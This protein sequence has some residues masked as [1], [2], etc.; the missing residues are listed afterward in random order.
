MTFWS[1]Q[2]QPWGVYA[3]VGTTVLAMNT[4]GTA[5]TFESGLTMTYN[6][7]QVNA[8]ANTYSGTATFSNVTKFTGA[9][10]INTTL[11]MGIVSAMNTA[12]TVSA[13]GGATLII[14]RR[15]GVQDGAGNIVWLLGVT[16]A[17]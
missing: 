13:L 6:G 10:T 2:Y 1:T 11:G 12:V 17:Q 5:M 8:G 3:T 15:V 4:L 14:N 9:V 16:S 7:T